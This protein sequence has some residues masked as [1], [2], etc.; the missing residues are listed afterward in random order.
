ME[1]LGIHSF[2]CVRGAS[3]FVV[4]AVALS[5]GAVQAVLCV[6]Y[7]VTMLIFLAFPTEGGDS[8]R[9]SSLAFPSIVQSYIGSHFLQVFALSPVQVLTRN[10]CAL[11]RTSLWYRIRGE[12]PP[13]E[14]GVSGFFAVCD[15][16]ASNQCGGDSVSGSIRLAPNFYVTAVGN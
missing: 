16:V 13:E 2:V 12:Q 4:D 11:V 14:F 8:F 15:N 5:V 9:D 6:G 7:V 3:A 10:I 1:L